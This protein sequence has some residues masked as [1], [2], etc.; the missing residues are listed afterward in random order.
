[1]RKDEG[2]PVA[3]SDWW[4]TFF[5]GAALETWRQ[6]HTREESRAQADGIARLLRLERGEEILDVPCGDGRLGL[7]LAA[8]GHRVHGLDTCEEGLSAARSSAAQAG[9]E[10]EFSRGDMRTLPWREHFDAAF[11]AGNSFGLF[12]DAG[13]RAFLGAVARAL[14]PGGR[15]LLEYPLVAELVGAHRLGRDWRLFSEHLLLT[16]SRLDER[17]ERLEARYTFVD[18]TR[19]GALEE[20]SASYRVYAARELEELLR[21]AGLRV[22]ARCGGMDGR[23]FWHASEEFLLVAV[24]A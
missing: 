3:A 2:Q 11:C 20:R 23:P 5:S 17:G 15:F 10:L 9:L 22:E 21:G 16:E 14:R 13:N 6:A 8:L 4:A 7:E 19:P 12:D 1:M 18:L 24:R